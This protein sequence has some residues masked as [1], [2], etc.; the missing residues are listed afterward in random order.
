[1]ALYLSPYAPLLLACTYFCQAVSQI[2]VPKIERHANSP[3]GSQ[4]SITFLFVGSSVCR[5]LPSDR[6]SRVCPCLKLVV[7][8]EKLCAIGSEDVESWV[9]QIDRR[10][11]LSG[12][13]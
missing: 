3:K 4:P 10:I 13:S 7:Q 9:E 6:P 1:M 11:Q 5:W 8:A 2:A 12:A